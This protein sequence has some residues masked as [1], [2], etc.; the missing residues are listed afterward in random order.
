MLYMVELDFTDRAREPEWEAWY[1]AHLQKLLAM[2][3]FRTA[4]RFKSIAP[5]T[6]PYLALYQID[7]MDV[8]ESAPYRAGAGR[9]SPG[10]WTRLMT[11]WH[12]N[13][14]DG[15]EAAADVPMAARLVIVDRPSASSPALPEGMRALRCLGLDRTVYERGIAVCTPHEARTLSARASAADTRVLRPLAP[16]MIAPA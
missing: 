11:N 3:G 10:E 16:R 2:P 9:S 1:T 5:A 4:Q 13:V 15:I 7:S 8:F 14:L 6:S 12:R